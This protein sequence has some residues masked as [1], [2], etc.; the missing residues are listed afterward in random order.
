M[1]NEII[2]ICSDSQAA[3]KAIGSVV[4]KSALTLE[5]WELL[6]KLAES[7]RIDLLWVPG[8]SNMK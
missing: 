2:F 6:N 8:H 1:S 4:I 5:C 3:L 7:N